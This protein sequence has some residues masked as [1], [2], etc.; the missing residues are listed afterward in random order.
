MRL[1]VSTEILAATPLTGWAL[2]NTLVATYSTH[3]QLAITIVVAGC[4]LLWRWREHR[5]IMKEESNGK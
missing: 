3:L 4:T 2:F 5:H 1:P